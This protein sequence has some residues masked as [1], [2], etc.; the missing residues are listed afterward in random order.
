M[1]PAQPHFAGG[2]LCTNPR[3]AAGDRK[4]VR[5]KVVILTWD[6]ALV[7]GPQLWEE[8]TGELGSK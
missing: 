3:G 2:R 1:G 5:Y 6:E 7:Q 8:G 4:A